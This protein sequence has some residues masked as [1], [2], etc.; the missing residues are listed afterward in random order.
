MTH[1]ACWYVY[2]LRVESIVL[3]GKWSKEKM[4][5]KSKCY[6]LLETIEGLMNKV[7]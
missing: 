4:L 6:E 1:G 7:I 2:V 5:I 3:C